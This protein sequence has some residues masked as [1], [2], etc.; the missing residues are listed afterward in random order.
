MGTTWHSHTTERRHPSQLH[1]LGWWVFK[2]KTWGVFIH[3]IKVEATRLRRESKLPATSQK[4][5]LWPKSWWLPL[6]GFLSDSPNKEFPNKDLWVA[7]LNSDT[8]SHRELRNRKKKPT[9]HIILAGS[10]RRGRPLNHTWEP[11]GPGMSRKLLL[12]S[13]SSL[14][15]IQFLQF[16]A[17]DLLCPPRPSQ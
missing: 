16:C 12:T 2:H 11:S 9:S 14:H 6:D 15:K 13:L 8:S 7:G 5:I 3:R 17:K 10:S 1:L 4:H